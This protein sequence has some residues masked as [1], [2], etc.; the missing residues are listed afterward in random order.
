[1]M[2]QF[3][4]KSN[5]LGPTGAKIGENLGSIMVYRYINFVI[6]HCTPL[7]LPYLTERS[8]GSY[9]KVEMYFTLGG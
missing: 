4:R 6:P 3:Y 7:L 9:A 5:E 2:N 8:D 1:M